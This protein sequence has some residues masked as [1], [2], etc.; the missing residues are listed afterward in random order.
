MTVTLSST[1]TVCPLVPRRRTIDL[2][3]IGYWIFFNNKIDETA[4]LNCFDWNDTRC[5]VG[6]KLRGIRKKEGK[7]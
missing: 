7:W 5:A 1:E 6:K 3:N 2:I 4:D